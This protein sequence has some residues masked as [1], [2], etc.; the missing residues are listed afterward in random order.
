MA[1][2]LIRINEATTR[3]LAALPGIGTTRARKIVRYRRSVGPLRNC[4]DLAAATG[5][6]LSRLNDVQSIDWTSGD[7]AGT[8]LPGIIGGIMV[9]VLIVAASR[10]GNAAGS[11]GALFHASTLMVALG[12]ALTAL[13]RWPTR[14]AAALVLPALAA[15]ASGLTLLGGIAVST[16]VSSA[17][18][19]LR[20]RILLTILFM[21]CAGTVFLTMLAPR[22]V[23]DYRT[24]WIEPVRRRHDL[25]RLLLLPFSLG[26]VVLD[27][28]NNLL[29]E[30]FALW[31][32]AILI[33]SAI[34]SRHGTFT[35]SLGDR[36]R[37]AVSFLEKNGKLSAVNERASLKLQGAYWLAGITLL[38]AA[39][40][41]I[42]DDL[43]MPGLIA[44]TEQ[45]ILR[46][47]HPDVTEVHKPF[48]LVGPRELIGEIQRAVTHLADIEIAD[49]V[50][51]VSR[52]C[53]AA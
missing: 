42:L 52:R 19:E 22:L 5:L 38:A 9:A 31:A 2:S 11:S 3:E 39:A 15:T 24:S 36:Q 40:N 25:A 30:I 51:G 32:G 47:S 4:Y 10:I 49:T 18:P 50:E 48:E 37:K 20:H 34:E 23:V 46:V 16:S 27:L 1:S 14:R 17:D 43:D 35:A 8:D 13:S 21:I 6:P 53:K 12:I 33:T 29:E 28:S 44:H 26:L 7:P 41:G 45:V